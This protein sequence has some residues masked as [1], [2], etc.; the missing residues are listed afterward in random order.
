MSKAGE[1]ST[2]IDFVDNDLETIPGN[3]KVRKEN[4]KKIFVE[5]ISLNDVI[6]NFFKNKCP[7]YIS[8][9]TEGSEY[10]IL[11]SFNFKIYKPKVFTIEHNQTDLEIKID[12]LMAL[13]D[14]VRVFKNLT[15]FDAWYVS[16]EA[17][18]KI[19]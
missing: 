16:K 14:Y 12:S 7:S 19:L 2:L 17:F 8:I 3:A 11:K 5:T 13:N 10:E 1:L 9:D 6:K 18:K 4:G 15:F